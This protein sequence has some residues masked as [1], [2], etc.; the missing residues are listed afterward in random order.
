MHDAAGFF[1]AGAGTVPGFLFYSSEPALAVMAM[2]ALMLAGCVGG[3]ADPKAPFRT[4][5]APEDTEKG[6]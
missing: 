2:M 5:E 1:F 4:M 3:M 6:R